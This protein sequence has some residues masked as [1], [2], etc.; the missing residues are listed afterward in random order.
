MEDFLNTGNNTN[1]DNYTA[2]RGSRGSVLYLHN[3][4][5]FTKD[6]SI[7]GVVFVRCLKRYCH[8]KGRIYLHDNTAY[9]SE[10]SMHCHGPM[11]AN[12]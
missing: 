3:G 10:D 6:V 1:R 2:V 12:Y 9:F 4:F 5:V 8:A 11:G 7:R